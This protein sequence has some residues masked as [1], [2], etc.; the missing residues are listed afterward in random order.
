MRAVSSP[1]GVWGGAPVDNEFGVFSHKNLPSGGNSFTVPQPLHGIQLDRAGGS[2]MSAVSS[3]SMVWG[4]ALADNE[5][6]VL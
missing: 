1:S 3:P 6:G 4:G 2:G 5:F